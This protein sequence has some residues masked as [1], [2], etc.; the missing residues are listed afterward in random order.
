MKLQKGDTVLVI[1]GKDKG[2]RG[3]I[4][5]VFSAERRAV[6]TG[7]NMRVRHIKKTAQQPGRKLTFEA[8]IDVSKLMLL[9]AK[10]GKPTRV[11]Y[12]LKDGKK[13][14]VSALSGDVIAKAAK[15]KATKAK[16]APKKE[17]KKEE[18]AASTTTSATPAAPTKKQPFWRRSKSAA[19]S[20]AGETGEQPRMEQDHTIPGQQVHVRK[21][22]RGS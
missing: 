2:K 1:S 15:P 18:K 13:L 7:I 6:V 4:D 16:A 21:G 14:R 8:S 10:S 20:Q 12:Q 5:R 19:D 22:G 17:D 3:T 11:H 9:D